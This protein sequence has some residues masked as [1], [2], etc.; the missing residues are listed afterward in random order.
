M[1]HALLGGTLKVSKIC[2]GTMTWGE[3]NSQNDAFAQMDFALDRGINF[4]DTAELY[5]V[6]PK[7]DTYT[8]TESIIGNWFKERQNRDKVILAS[9]VAGPSKWEH[10][11]GGKAWLNAEQIKKALDG[12]LQRLQTDYIDL[13][14][15]HWPNRR[16]TF[17]GNDSYTHNRQDG[18]DNFLEVLEA[19]SKE[20]ANGR[21]RHV[22]V[23]NETPWGLMKYLEL[24]RQNDLA[25]MASIQNPYNLLNRVFESGL[26]EISIRENVPLLAYSPLAFGVLSGKYLKGQKPAGSRLDKFGGHFSR[27]TQDL[28]TSATNQYV[29]IAEKFGYQPAQMA[30]AFINSRA[31]LGAN[32]IGAT[33]LEQLQENIE[34]ADC[35][36]NSECLAAIDAIHHKIKNPCP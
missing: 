11:P 14:Q 4:F 35:T 10:I 27:Y 1:K 34:S 31:F 20:V 24:A 36:L 28:A 5:P 29:K 33:N 30:L 17:F 26:A 16:T 21:I 6:P 32:I 19:L 18:D 3:Q 8:K 25:V 13:Y 9:K 22:G 2:L 23:S 7:A 15:L 12:S